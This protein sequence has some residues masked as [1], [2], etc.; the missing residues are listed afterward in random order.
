M[1]SKLLV[2]MRQK[3]F[4]FKS[5][6][7]NSLIKSP[8][9][10]QNRDSL[11]LNWAIRGLGLGQLNI[12]VNNRLNL[13]QIEGDRLSPDIIEKLVRKALAEAIYI[14]YEEVVESKVDFDL[15][16]EISLL[17]EHESYTEVESLISNRKEVSWFKEV[18]PFE[19][20]IRRYE[21]VKL[22]VLK[23]EYKESNFEDYK[24]YLLK[25]FVKGEKKIISIKNK[26]I[27]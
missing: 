3:E 20:E 12:S 10:Y 25:N 16:K 23:T 2:K 21:E 1:I 24:E 14:N 17:D 6:K 9:L 7:G 19:D 18:K 8:Q 27:N 15:K 11:L 22:Y 13:L 26:T 5:K 4:F